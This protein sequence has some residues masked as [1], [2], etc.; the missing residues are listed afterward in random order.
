MAILPSMMAQLQ[1]SSYLP[2]FL[3]TYSYR[4]FLTES[5]E[6]YAAH[7]LRL[8]PNLGQILR[9]KQVR[10]IGATIFALII[11]AY[12]FFRGPRM[13]FNFDYLGAVH[14]AVHPA[15]T[16][17][18]A[19]CAEKTVDW[20]RF[21]YTQYVTNTEYLCNSVM[22]FETLHRLGSK[23]DRLMMYPSRMHPD[24]DPTSSSPES[25]LLLKAQNDY[26]VKLMPIEVQHRSGRD[27]KND[28]PLFQ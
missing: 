3:Q 2:S 8:K 5:A 13:S 23:A 7:A 1:Q 20:S 28:Y 15:N 25:R 9:S 18:L 27:C 14:G 4:P 17:A 26:G 21:A 6:M 24:P 12:F 10:I 11:F 19:E 22:L 16:A